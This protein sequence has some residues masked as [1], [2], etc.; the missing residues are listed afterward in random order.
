[1]KR[2]ILLATLMIGS[3][4]FSE[5][6]EVTH[7]K[8]KYINLEDSKALEIKEGDFL[9]I[10]EEDGAIKVGE[11]RVLK[12]KGNKAQAYLVIGDVE[13]GY[14]LRIK[15]ENEDDFDRGS[16]FGDSEDAKSASSPF[17]RGQSIS[18]ST[19]SARRAGKSFA[20]ESGMLR[21]VL[22]MRNIRAQYR[23]TNS[24]TLGFGY[25]NY[26]IDFDIET[27]SLS[28]TTSNILNVSGDSVSLLGSTWFNGTAFSQGGYARGE[29]AYTSLKANDS[30]GF[31]TVGVGDIDVS[32]GVSGI[33]AKASVGYHW[34]WQTIYSNLYAGLQYYSMDGEATASSDDVN[35]SVSE[36]S[37]GTGF[38]FGFSIG[39]AF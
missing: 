34:Q 33:E 23:V 11:A 32:S 29:I 38:D 18:R 35:S 17:N 19:K 2:A 13:E 26:D 6:M 7:V 37:S 28:G 30:N 36:T 22:G 9:S 16:A 3:M 8:R 25:T 10:Y 27:T 31:N 15:Q 39:I 4:S 21:N 1:M 14:R 12:V 5:A 24:S 20:V